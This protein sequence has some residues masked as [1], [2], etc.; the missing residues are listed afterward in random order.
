[1]NLDFKNHNFIITGISRGIGKNIAQKFLKL[2]A[3]VI[4][5]STKKTL[6]NKNKRFIKFSQ[7]MLKNIFCTLK[8]TK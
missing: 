4:G 2:G 5:A 8:E 6:I 3:N 1:M 7:L